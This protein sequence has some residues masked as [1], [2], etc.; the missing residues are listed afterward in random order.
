MKLKNQNFIGINSRN[1]NSSMMYN[2][3][4]Y[5]NSLNLESKM[6]SIGAQSKI[7]QMAI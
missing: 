1:R 7:I 2:S 6:S 5:K 3:V 4:E